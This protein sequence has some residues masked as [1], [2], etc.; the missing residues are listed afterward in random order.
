MKTLLIYPTPVSVVPYGIAYISDV[1]DSCGFDIKVIINTFKGYYT[2]EDIVT[3]AENYKP[4]IIALSFSTLQVLSVY[5]LI[6][7]LKKK[8]NALI[9]CGGPH[10]SALPDEVIRHG[11]DIVVRGEGEITTR[12]LCAAFAS[13][14][15]GAEFDREELGRRLKEIA[16][17]TFSCEGQVFSTEPRKRNSDLDALPLPSFKGIDKSIFLAADGSYKGFNKIE[18]GR[19]CPNHCTFCDRSVFGQK[20]VTKSP[21][22]LIEDIIKIKS[23]YNINDFY[24]TDDTFT[25]HPDYVYEVC[26]LLEKNS[27]GISWA[28]ASRV[29]TINKKMSERMKEVGCRRIIFGVESGSNDWLARTRKGYTVDVPIKALNFTYDAKIETHVN[30]MYGYPWETVENIQSQIEFVTYVKKMVNVFQ[31]YGAL[32]P[33]PNTEAYEENKKEYNIGEWWLKEKYQ[34]CGQVIYQ[35]AIDPYKVSTFYHRNLHDDT[36]VYHD[37]FFPFSREYKNK[38]KEFAFL[39]GKHNL[40]AQYSSRFKQQA[41]YLLGVLSRNAYEY[42]PSLEIS[43]MSHLGLRNHLHEF[44]KTG[45]FIKK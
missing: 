9:L 1:F 29:N 31:T 30:L 8:T 36:Y 16:G 45:E 37:Y 25:I 40:K 42:A 43:I 34:S 33:Y 35:N 7:E 3:T 6:S 13:S 41:Y 20:Y 12:E 26:D 24:F 18:N 19:G 15:R 32:I 10:P 39:L 14:W 28:C 21:N 2:N 38:V 4:D 44:R 5:G 11:A 17:V 27:I 22:R 23:Q